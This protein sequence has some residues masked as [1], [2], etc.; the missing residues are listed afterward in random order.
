MNSKLKILCLICSVVA[1]LTLITCIAKAQNYVST[2]AGDGTNAY[3]DGDTAT[4]KFKGPFGMCIDLQ[5][6]LYIADNSNHRIRKISTDGTVTTLAGT[7]VAGYLDGPGSTAKFNAPSDLCAD[8]NGNIYVSDFQ[9]QY[10]RKIAPDGTV[11]TIAGSGIAGYM[12][13][14][15]NVAE[16]N[17]PRGICI[18][19]QGNLFIADSWN[20][21]IRKIDASGNVTT[22]A[23]GGDTI[24]VQS[25]G[26]YRDASDTSA[27]F[28]VPCGMSI[29]ADGNLY[30]ADAYNHRIRKV[31]PEGVV[32]TIAGTGDIGSSAGGYE[33]GS[34]DVARFN[35]PTEV[36][37]DQQGNIYVGDSYN[38]RVRLVANSEVSTVAGNG[39]AGYVDGIDTAAEFKSPRGIVE[40]I[41]GNHLYV[42]DNSNHVIRKITLEIAT[43]I[44]SETSAI[45]F[46]IFPNPASDH[47]FISSPNQLKE[48]FMMDVLGRKM[49]SQ[50]FESSVFST[51]LNL[52]DIPTGYYLLQM[53]TVSDKVVTTKLMISH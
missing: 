43:G 32:S 36:Y 47:V 2:Y 42:C 35:T 33:D 1:A 5:G 10:I 17:Y 25:Q 49:L 15:S 26:N 50:S 24:G 52:Q 28:N 37:I 44:E 18:D 13:G 19:T 45:P 46:S 29:D 3:A 4:C 30:V 40:D 20:H 21:R 41:S 51:T 27:R 34:I 6:N 8:A 23:G 11:S 9:N 12:D 22:L 31:T 16:F 38:N 7:G 39:I 53:K 14:A 48:I